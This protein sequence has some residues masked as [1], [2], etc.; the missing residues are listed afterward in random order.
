MSLFNSVW[1]VTTGTDPDR[2]VGRVVAVRET[3]DG[4]VMAAD[5]VEIRGCCSIW[6]WEEDASKCTPPVRD[7]RH[8]DHWV[9]ITPWVVA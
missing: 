2:R 7:W 3:E 6:Y 8:H 9:R 1:V 5:R 4:A